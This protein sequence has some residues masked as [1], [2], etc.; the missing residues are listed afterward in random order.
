MC[1]FEWI[2]RLQLADFDSHIFG[3]V[4]SFR[5]RNYTLQ[6]DMPSNTLETKKVANHA[7]K[8]KLM[9]IVPMSPTDLVAETETW[10]IRAFANPCCHCDHIRNPGSGSFLV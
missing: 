9:Q 6:R 5:L 10:N 3:D 7:G 2:V 4:L 8:E 1:S